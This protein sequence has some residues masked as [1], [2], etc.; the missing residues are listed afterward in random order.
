MQRTAA[1]TE[2][3]RRSSGDASAAEG[4]KVFK[5]SEV[6]GDTSPNYLKTILALA[7]WL[8]TIH[9]NAALVLF[10]IFFL[11][12]HKAFLLFGL[13]FV[14]M[15]IPVDEKSKFGRKLSRRKKK[16]WVCFRYICKHVCAYFPITLHVEDMKAFHPSR[17][18]VFGYEPHS[19]LP[20]GV[21]A[22]ADNTCFMP[23][24]KIKVLASSAIFYTPFLRHIWTWLGLT[25]V[26]K[27]RFTSLLDAGYSC[28]L[29]PGGVQ[30]AFLIEHG[31]EIAFLKSRRGF[32][33]IAMEKGKPLV[34]VFCF[35]Q[36][37]VYKWWKP[38]GK[39]VLNFARA[40][41][42]SPVYFWGIFGSPIPFKHPM[43]VVV[44]RPIEL[45]KTPE[46]TPEEVAKIHSQFVEALQDLF[47]RH[48][49][50]AGYPNLELRIV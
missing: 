22:L 41:K 21:V 4:E 33:R 27:K 11:S 29:I 6:F 44:G 9:F 14:L 35:G 1:A 42:F 40:V 23:L 37:N 5:G 47:E 36:S 45:E 13:L 28:I 30:E 38:G 8:G 49:A 32:V 20:I 43:H 16:I 39:L 50:R 24:P 10:A 31:S 17:A 19:V 34:P 15:V 2:E 7:L 48:K 46:P 18:Y 26:T 12:L 25:P 3:P